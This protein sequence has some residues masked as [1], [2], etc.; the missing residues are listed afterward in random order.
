MFACCIENK[1]TVYFNPFGIQLCV[2][3]VARP[4][5]REEYNHIVGMSDQGT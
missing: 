3:M 5:P 4:A 2:C 1:C